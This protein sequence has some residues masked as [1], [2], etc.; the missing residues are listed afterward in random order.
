MSFLGVPPFRSDDTALTAKYFLDAKEAYWFFYV[1][2]LPIL[3]SLSRL[4]S[5]FSQ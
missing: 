4:S 5:N 1:F 3:W 2:I